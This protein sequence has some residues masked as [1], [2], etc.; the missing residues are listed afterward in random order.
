MSGTITLLCWVIDTPTKQIFPVEI[1]RDKLW[2]CVKDAIKEKEKPEFDDIPANT[3]DLW[4]VRHCAIS[5]VVAQLS[6]QKVT[7]S[8][9]HRSLLESE[10]FLKTVTATDPLDSIGPLSTDF[11]QPVPDDP[12]NIIIVKRPPGG[13]LLIAGYILTN[14]AL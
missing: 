13:S 6:I 1:A 3:L 14:F 7:I 4:K 9:S 12:I 5:H 2:G 10:D 11:N 8:R